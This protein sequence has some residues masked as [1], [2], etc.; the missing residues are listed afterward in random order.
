MNIDEVESRRL[1]LLAGHC[2]KLSYCNSLITQLYNKNV[3]SDQLDT[4]FFPINLDGSVNEKIIDST[5]IG[6]IPGTLADTFNFC[7]GDPSDPKVAWRNPHEKEV[8]EIFGRLLG[9]EEPS[10]YMTGCGSESNLACIWWSKLNLIM[11][12][13]TLI[14]EFK[15]KLA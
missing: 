1:W 13:R 6:I 4:C 8:I 14:K 7:Y 2:K 15:E 3:G 5:N 11:N 10:G 12:S 9:I